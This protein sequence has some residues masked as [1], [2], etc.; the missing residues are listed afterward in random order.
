MA[1]R[2]HNDNGLSRAVAFHISSDKSLCY[3][4]VRWL[5]IGEPFRVTKY[6]ATANWTML[7]ECHE[8]GYRSK[9]IKT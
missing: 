5:E 2:R 8:G 7:G 4:E 3:V 9:G 1:G 6:Y